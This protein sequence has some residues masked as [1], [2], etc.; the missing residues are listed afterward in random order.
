MSLF[1]EGTFESVMASWRGEPLAA[2]RPLSLDSVTAARQFLA[3]FAARPDDRL[4]LRRLVAERITT[5]SYG[6]GDAELLDRLAAWIASG[7]LRLVALD[8][9]PLGSWGD[10]GGE[11][12]AP[13]AEARDAV[14]ELTWITIALV[15]EDDKPIPGERYRVEL[16]DGSIREGRL[17]GEGLARFRDIDPGECVVTFPDLDEEAWV[18]IGKTAEP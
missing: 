1:L 13:P 3:R 14:T 16:P 10:A 7:E 17:D 12:E 5:P 15:G 11:A 4:R 8:R 18:P 2:G 6:L 9:A